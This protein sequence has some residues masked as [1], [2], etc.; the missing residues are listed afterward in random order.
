[1]LWLV[2]KQN[3][4]AQKTNQKTPLIVYFFISLFILF[5]FLGLHPQHLFPFKKKITGV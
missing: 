4:K 3:K 1:M 5:C 2:Q